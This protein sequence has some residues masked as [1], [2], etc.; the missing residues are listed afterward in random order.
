MHPSPHPSI[1]HPSIHQCTHPFIPPSLHPSVHPSIHPPVPLSTHPPSV[2]PFIC[3]SSTHHPSNHPSSICPS[4]HL[5]IYPSIQSPTNHPSV[6][7][8]THLPAYPSTPLG[9][10]P[11]TP[12]VHPPV[13]PSIH[14]PICSSVYLLT[15]P[16]PSICPS[17]HLSTHCFFHLSIYPPIHVIFIKIFY[18][19]WPR[20]MTLLGLSSLFFR[21][22]QH[23]Y[24]AALL[25]GSHELMYA[26]L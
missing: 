2:Y 16:P 21:M 19:A 8:S 3:C 17:S 7:L 6:H 13:H 12:P 1:I 20:Y 18:L 14:P 9:F 22:G 26:Q 5:L 24:L 15:R 11:S 23:P 25:C 10:H 4:V